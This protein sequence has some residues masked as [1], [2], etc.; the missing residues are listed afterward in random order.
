MYRES[1]FTS[2]SVKKDSQYFMTQAGMMRS[3][4]SGHNFSL[5]S[6]PV[7]LGVGPSDFQSQPRTV[8]LRGERTAYRGEVALEQQVLDAHVIVEVLQVAQLRHG[9]VCVCRDRGST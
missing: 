5:D 6:A 8:R 2:I 1:F 7:F 4:L 9:A 3:V